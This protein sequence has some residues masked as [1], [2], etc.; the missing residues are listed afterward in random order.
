MTEFREE[1]EAHWK[2]I[3]KLLR[4]AKAELTFDLLEF[5]YI[6]AMVHGYKHKEEEKC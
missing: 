3:D 4:I 5:L 6:E 2:F 1:A